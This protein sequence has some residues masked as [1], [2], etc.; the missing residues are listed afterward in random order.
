V[1]GALLPLA[2]YEGLF[3][4]LVGCAA[5]WLCGRRGLAL[6]L[7]AAAA[8]P[9]AVYGLISW[10]H[11][12]YLVP[13]TVLIKGSRPEL[14]PLGLMKFAA[15]YSP[16]KEMVGIRQIL[17]Q[18]H[19]TV[20]LVALLA[21]FAHRSRR[22]G[23]SWDTA[24]V[25]LAVLLATTLLHMQ[26]AAVGWFYRYEAYLLVAGFFTLGFAYRVGRGARATERLSFA[27]LPV[28]VACG[29]LGFFAV[30]PFVQRSVEAA[31]ISPQ[32]AQNIHD[33]QVQMGRF[34]ARYYPQGGVAANDIGAVSFFG[35]PHLV[36]LVGLA[37]MEVA[38][39]KRRGGF[40]LPF[41]LDLLRK[42][43]VEVLIV[44]DEVLAKWGMDPRPALER[45]GRWTIRENVIS[46]F[47]TISFYAVDAGG[48]E[49]LRGQLEEFIRELPP[50]VT[51][52]ID[53][54]R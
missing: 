52:R 26:F 5:L 18:R 4:V 10:A 19:V 53:P 3:L 39:A 15:G 47:D 2:R 27:R 42:K 6:R 25:M 40:D 11:G 49:R 16:N 13:N 17:D 20:L 12:W 51:V 46:A 50:A 9:V 37:S 33:Q 38:D 34:V 22:Q 23:R 54:P 36:D 7:G 43:N 24:Q 45:V 35:D 48:S 41:L 30:Q 8:A 21:A 44:Y 31:R 32:A 29:G 1:C 14:T 28:L